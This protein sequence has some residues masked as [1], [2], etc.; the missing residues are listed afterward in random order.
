MSY[1]I[2]GNVFTFPEGNASTNRVYTYA[3]GFAEIGI[4][5]HVVTVGDDYQKQKTGEIEGIKFFNSFKPDSRNSNFFLRNIPKF[6]K[7]FRA[8]Q[9]VRELNKKDSVSVIIVYTKLLRVHILSYLLA[10]FLGAKL[11]IENSE[12]PLR[13]YRNGIVNKFIG[14]Y[15]LFVELHTFD[16]ILLITN[17][18]VDFYKPRIRD[19]RKILLVPSTVDPSRFA[20]PKSNILPYEYIGYF[21][22]LNF[23]RDRLDLLLDAFKALTINHPDIHLVMGGATSPEDRALIKRKIEEIEMQDKVLLLN[24]LGREEITKYIVNA[25]V[26]VMVR[27]NHPDTNA[28]YPSKLT[29]YLSTGN[30]VISVNVGEISIYLTD[31]VN[32]Y[33]VNPNNPNEIGDK[34]MYILNNYSLA[35][36][37]GKRGQQL[38]HEIFNYAVQSK[39]I[40]NFVE[41][42]KKP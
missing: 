32:A 16:A 31:M 18:L 11:V 40:V 15:R 9:Y 3:K 19:H 22:F 37:V 23:H 39:R 33:L 41:S 14:E 1:I 26:L 12:H 20:F 29:E 35:L 36:E 4:N 34:L 17:I 2:I 27:S 38:T 13:Y 28:S 30:P 8:I 21:G 5:T 10:R 6:F 25:K 24:Y 7:Y 42:I